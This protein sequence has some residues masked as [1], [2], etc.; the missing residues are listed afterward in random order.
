MGIKEPGRAV[1][2]HTAN[3]RGT[4]GASPPPI[5]SRDTEGIATPDH[6]PPRGHR[7]PRGTRHRHREE[8][9]VSGIAT[10]NTLFQEQTGIRHRHRQQVPVPGLS[11]GIATGTRA[12]SPPRTTMAWHRHHAGTGHRHPRPRTWH[13][14]QIHG[15]GIATLT[16]DPQELGIVTKNLKAKPRH[17]HQRLIISPD[18]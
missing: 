6:A 12:A 5:T 14:H 13:R 15:Q 11:P 16:I 1:K 8:Q 10:V 17:R 4:Q 9:R 18:K 3:L 2:I 7:H